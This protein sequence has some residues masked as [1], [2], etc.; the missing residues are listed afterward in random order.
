MKRTTILIFALS[1]LPNGDFLFSDSGVR[2]EPHGRLLLSEP[3]ESV[4]IRNGAVFTRPDTPV[5]GEKSVAGTITGT[6]EVIDGKMGKALRLRG[7]SQVRYLQGAPVVDLAGGELSFQV[8]LNFDPADKNERTRTVLR[9]QMFAT[10]MGPGHS[11]VSVYSCLEDVSFCVRNQDGNLL[12]VK[13]VPFV[14]KPGAWHHLALR[15]GNEL[16]LWCDGEKKETV[17]WEGLFGAVPVKRDELYLILGSLIGWST[18]ESEFALDDLMIRGPAPGQISTRPRAC[19]PLLD[20]AP[21]VDGKLT[22]P[23]WQKAAKISGFTSFDKR[24]IVAVQ[25]RMHAAYTAK[26]LYFGLEATLSQNRSPRATLT[27][28]DAPIY[29][30]HDSVEVFLQPA[31]APDGYYQFIASA[32][33]TQFDARTVADKA[34]V[35]GYNPEWEVKTDGKPGQWT[36]EVFVPFGS[37]GVSRPPKADE[38]WKANFCLDDA[39]GFSSAATWAF[40][41]GN[42]NNPAYFGELVFTGRERSLRQEKF[43]GF[44]LGEPAVTM[45][46]T[47]AFQPIVTVKSEILDSKGNSIFKYEQPLRDAN[48]TEIR[49]QP[50]TTGQYVMTVSAADEQG[51]SLF[52]Q[53]LSFQTAKA[54]SLFVANYP[55]AGYLQLKADI[56][57]M[58]EPVAEVRCGI[59]SSEGK[60]VGSVALKDFVNGVSSSRYAN[61]KLL[62]GDYEVE[63]RAMAAPGA[64]ATE[65]KALETAKQALRIF[66]QP[67]WW[68]NDLGVDHSV[69]PPFQPVKETADALSVWGRDYVFG[70]SIFPQQI[71]SQKESL[72]AASPTLNLKVAGVVTDLTK[73]GRSKGV[74]QP[75]AV[76]LTGNQTVGDIAVT[77]HSTVEF[78]GFTRF[79]L[80]LTPSKPTQVDEL[81]L[82][83]PLQKELVKF[84]LASTGASGNV[85][86]FE[87]PY[88]SSFLPYLWL[89]ND[90]MGIAFYSERDQY[91]TP[92]DKKMLQV[93]PG[94]KATTLRANFVAQ[95]TTLSKPISYSF[96]LMATPVRPIPQND[97]YAY[98]SWNHNSSFTYPEHLTYPLPEGGVPKEG[99][100][101]FSLKRSELKARSNTEVFSLQAGKKSLN[102]FLLTPDRPNEFAL[103]LNDQRIL[104][105]EVPIDARSFSAMAV[106]WD[107]SNVA[108]YCN[109]KLSGKAPNP[110]MEELLTRAP[111]QLRF[112]CRGEWQG[113]TGII[114]DEIR[115]SRGARW[116]GESYSA[117]NAPLEREEDT[118]LLDSLN[119]SFRPDGEDA[120][121]T[122]GGTPSIGS[123]FVAGKFGQALQLQVGPV[124][125][126]YEVMQEIGVKVTSH[127]LWQEAMRKYYAQPV[128]FGDTVPKLK[129]E[130]DNYH[131]HGIKIVPYA[132]YPAVGGPSPLLDQFRDEWGIRP[133]S[134]L[135]W[136]FAGAPEGYHLYNCCLQAKGFADYLVGGAVWA[137]DTFGFDGVYTDGL[138]HVYACQNEAHGCGY[139]D[140]EGNRRSTWPMFATREAVK[141]MYRCIKSRR[142]DGFLVNHASFDYIMPTLS[143]S[144][145]LYTGEHEDYENLLTAR[146]RFCSKPWGVYVT[147]LGSSEHIYSS[148]H[149]MTSLLNGVSIWGSGLLGRNDFARKEARLRQT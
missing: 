128:L 141:R 112:G 72:L 39:A 50:L 127:W 59:K 25:P 107:A 79:D 75:D 146:V 14:W 46:L 97:P 73:A 106:T 134:T 54:V 37:L 95:S 111:S 2:A 87:K 118:L 110:G 6:S 62:P 23:F 5:E 66:P 89:G 31:S 143:F 68:K 122:A 124:R 136:Q 90:D 65:G 145:V 15:W 1:L 137:M 57:G 125:T 47:G 76:S 101:E 132:A 63:A 64:D 149:T 43:A 42:Y 142:P 104:A 29:A 22:D 80:T 100:L 99:T 77:W 44:E 41:G 139:R 34:D 74:S 138:T 19:L 32:S 9:N 119:G 109:G 4:D 16:Q 45:K 130:V 144:D 20:D 67:T 60:L 35:G 17:P 105:A 123:S 27:E 10:F 24:D 13:R 49:P 30:G 108:V 135:P 48:S 91:W 58:K 147:T 85:L 38:V 133:V 120:K 21:T 117:A 56:R 28:R 140:D 92:N 78:D 33:G 71:I 82:S 70:K 26:G 103:F 98:P 11:K 53:N 121:T 12:T 96:G 93:I 94:E 69:P 88:D 40:T 86:V 18:V 113:Y 115:L 51:Q 61:D 3:F 114:V 81:A 36:A 131:K 7:L 102:A 148:L 83:L 8:A 84:L 52:Y 116:R 126:P 129:E 55:Y